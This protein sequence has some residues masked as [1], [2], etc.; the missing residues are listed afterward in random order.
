MV[1]RLTFEGLVVTPVRED[2]FLDVFVEAFL[3]AVHVLKE[4]A[5]SSFALFKRPS[6][7]GLL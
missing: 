7:A 5:F 2:V 1:G 4:V 6:F 3:H